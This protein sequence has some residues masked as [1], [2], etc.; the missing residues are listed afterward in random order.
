MAW[1][2]EGTYFENCSCEAPCPCSVSLDSGADYDR[3][4][5]LFAFHIESGDVDGVDV[6]GLCAAI[7]GDTPQLMTDGNWKVGLV[8]DA[9]ANDEQAEKLGAVFSGQLGGPP[10]ALG[11]MLGELLGIER[12]SFDWSEDGLDHRVRI[13]DAVD[14]RAEDLVPLGVETGEPAKVTGVGHPVSSTLTIARSKGSTGS[15][16]GVGFDNDGKSAFSAPFSW[17]A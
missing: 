1:N 15:I 17:A 16:F 5:L 9:A 6:S 10:G 11:P 7:V 12:A 8:L 13:G 3:C 14:M 2:L 4:K